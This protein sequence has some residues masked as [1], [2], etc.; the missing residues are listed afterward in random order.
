MSDQVEQQYL[1]LDMASV[2]INV[3]GNNKF[4]DTT[5]YPVTKTLRASANKA[6]SNGRGGNLSSQQ[7]GGGQNNSY[8]LDLEM[9]QHS[10]DLMLTSNYNHSTQGYQ[11][12]SVA[13]YMK[14]RLHRKTRELQNQESD[15]EHEK[16]IKGTLPATQL[17]FLNQIQT[18][19]SGTKSGSGSGNH[20]QRPNS[21]MDNHSGPYVVLPT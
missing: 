17:S 15:L 11:P 14:Q 5:I 4:N 12:S 18:K 1:T 8:L 3:D 20:P 19:T 16:K 21:M 9:S 13:H 2:I 6:N 10:P 7:N